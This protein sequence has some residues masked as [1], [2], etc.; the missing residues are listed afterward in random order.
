MAGDIDLQRHAQ[1]LF[2]AVG[3][4]VGQQLGARVTM[5]IVLRVEADTPL[6]P[7]D[8]GLPHYAVTVQRGSET[9]VI[10]VC[11]TSHSAALLA[12]W[13]QLQQRGLIE[14]PERT[15]KAALEADRLGPVS[16]GHVRVKLRL[17]PK[18]A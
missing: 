2:G 9:V 4:G 17:Q 3:L 7:C 5:P 16:Q 14:M 1:A 15:V 11:A 10:G 6:E 18:G 8:C 13:W 12:V